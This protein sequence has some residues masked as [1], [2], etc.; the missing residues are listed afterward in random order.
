MKA[1]HSI[2]YGILFTT[3]LMIAFG[4]TKKTNQQTQS[5]ETDPTITQAVAVLY[6]TEGNHISGV[7]TFTKESD[8]IRIV[9]TIKGLSQGKHGFHIHKYGDCSAADGSSAGG[10]YNP[11]NV[12]HG[13]PDSDIRHAGDLGNI[14]AGADSVGNYDRFDTHIAF[15]GL[16]SII[17]RA[18][19]VHSGEDDYSSQPSGNAG[20]RVACGVIGIAAEQ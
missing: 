4:C 11:D 9:A 17:G 6:P 12:D 15:D 19:V 20:S 14:E 2:S 7:V 3:G 13:G 16:H 18:I 1:F 8:G 5:K 10:H